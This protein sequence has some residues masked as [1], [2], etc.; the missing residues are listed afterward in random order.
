MN[1]L[2]AF[3]IGLKSNYKA[4]QNFEYSSHIYI[5]KNR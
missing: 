3:Y 2:K 4:R 5:L 1:F